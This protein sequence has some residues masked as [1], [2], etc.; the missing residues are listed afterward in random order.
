MRTIPCKLEISDCTMPQH[1]RVELPG[2]WSFEFR[3]CDYH[4][5]PDIDVFLDCLGRGE[6]CSV[7]PET[8]DALKTL[9]ASL[10]LLRKRPSLDNV[11]KDADARRAWQDRRF[12]A[13]LSILAVRPKPA[14]PPEPE[15]VP[16]DELEPFPTI[17]RRW[18][19]ASNARPAPAA[20]T[21]R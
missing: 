1:I 3:D 18:T 2:G 13:G 6:P 8:A 21:P 14:T 20:P 16:V 9:G 17:F 12:K 5:V 11:G 15:E 4:E 19:S 7:T 10:Q